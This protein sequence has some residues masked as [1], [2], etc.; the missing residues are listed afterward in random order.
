MSHHRRDASLVV[1]AA[2]VVG[3]GSAVAR[4]QSSGPDPLAPLD[5]LVGKWTSRS[6]GQP[7]QGTGEREYVRV[8]GSRFIQARNTV[9]YPPQPK[10][11]K[12]E[13]HED[14]GFFGFDRARKK[15]IYRQ[16]HSEGF[17]NQYAA[18]PPSTPASIVFTTEAIENIPAGWRARETYTRLASG[19]VEEVFELAEPGKEFETYSRTRLSRVR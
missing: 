13:R 4:S 8:L 19:D 9:T 12:G 16:F 18:D 17:V 6:D 15:L 14:V 3:L 5:F 2:V 1:V 11:P 7:G 10:N